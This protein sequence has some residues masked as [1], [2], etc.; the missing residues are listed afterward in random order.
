M[1]ILSGTQGVP[2]EG[3]EAILRTPEQGGKGAVLSLTKV[4][5]PCS[6]LKRAKTTTTSPLLPEA[7]RAAV[8]MPTEGAVLAGLRPYRGLCSSSRMSKVRKVEV[9]SERLH[10]SH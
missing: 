4:P 3:G 7:E 5:G 6:W 9:R 10:V 2:G 1:K 8:Q